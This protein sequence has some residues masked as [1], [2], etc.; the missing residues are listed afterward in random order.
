MMR[1]LLFIFLFSL[2]SLVLAQRPSKVVVKKFDNG[3]AEIV[4]YYQGEKIPENLV[5]QER[6]NVDGKIVKEQNYKDIKLH[7][8]YRE[9]KEF[10]GTLVKELNYAH[11][12]L[13]GEQKYFF[14]DGRVKFLLNYAGGKLNGVQKEYFFK[15]DT[16]AA[17]H[18]YDAGI[19]HGM[20]QRWGKDGQKLYQLNFVA[21][22][23]D[24]I[25]RMWQN[26]Q[27]ME[28]RWKTGQFEEVVEEWTASQAKWVRVYEW[29][30]TGDSLNIKLGKQVDRETKYYE[31]GSIAAMLEPGDPG[32]ITEYH[33]NGKVK[34]EGQGTFENPIGTW[35]YYHMN[36]EKSR[37]GQFENGNPIGVWRNW[38]EKGRM[39]REEV[40]NAEGP[41]RESWKVLSYH[42]NDKKAYEGQLTDKGYKTGDWNYWFE[43]GNKHKEETWKL[44]C[45]TGKRPVLASYTEFTPAGK[46]LLK[47]HE[48]EMMEH[49]Y[50]ESGTLKSVTTQLY[51]QRDPCKDPAPE[52][53]NAGR[54]EKKISGSSGYFEK[55]V[56]E[57]VILTE[58]G[59]S[60]MHERFDN[61]S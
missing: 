43:T 4:N 55:I 53:Y 5:K 13:D 1:T 16:I 61:E 44:E 52:V 12:A 19:Y 3:K 23:P 41:K 21:G 35:V 38:D 32:K 8:A 24:G 30:N 28:E 58:S 59:D 60:R 14:S 45:G 29:E 31:S 37:Q 36:G 26:G 27:K 15:E 46:G 40:M 25:Q 57:R 42:W 39:T 22:K 20:Q 51:A 11:G 10:D 50:Y 18:N 33:P 6:F 49:A 56:T 34:G 54:F 48:R 17:V 47:G 7:G 9:Y 2:S